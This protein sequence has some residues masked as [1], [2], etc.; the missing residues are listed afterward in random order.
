MLWR[1]KHRQTHSLPSLIPRPLSLLPRG[2][3]MRLTH[4]LA[5]VKPVGQH[6]DCYMLLGNQRSL[7]YMEVNSLTSSFLSPSAPSF[8]YMSN[9]RCSLGSSLQLRPLELLLPN[10][11]HFSCCFSIASASAV[12]HQLH[13]LQLLL[14]DCV[15]VQSL[16]TS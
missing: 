3:G 1:E 13:P 15:K 14:P 12:P 11:V 7:M 10:C 4:C 6:Q 8:A 5:L 9:F 2:L 16:H